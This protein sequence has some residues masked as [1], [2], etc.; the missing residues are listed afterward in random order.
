MLFQLLHVGVHADRVD[1]R[2][3]TL[4]RCT[5][6]IDASAL[7]NLAGITLYMRQ[8]APLAIA[9]MG[10]LTAGQEIAGHVAAHGPKVAYISETAR[11]E[12]K[13][14]GYRTVYFLDS[15]QSLAPWPAWTLQKSEPT[16][17]GSC[18]MG[19]MPVLDMKQLLDACLIGQKAA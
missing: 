11:W 13:G 1:C 18:R 7:T 8:Q 6:V 4:Q 16:L 19:R 10:C 12:P 9:P 14:A 3:N 2:Q 15:G 17:A 5:A